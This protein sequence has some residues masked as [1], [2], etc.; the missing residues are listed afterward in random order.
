MR[1]CKFNVKNVTIQFQPW[2]DETETDGSRLYTA[3]AKDLQWSLSLSDPT[4]NELHIKYLGRTGKEESSNIG[5]VYSMLMSIREITVQRHEDADEQTFLRIISIGRV[6]VKCLASQWPNPV[7]SLARKTHGDPNDSLLVLLLDISSP[8]FCERLD[9]LASMLKIWSFKSTS[10]TSPPRR[11]LNFVPRLVLGLFVRD[12]AA[13]LIPVDQPS[14]SIIVSSTQATFSFST[15]FKSLPLGRPNFAESCSS[16]YIPIEL[17]GEGHA[18]LGPA[19]MT[20]LSHRLDLDE[21]DRVSKYVESPSTFGDPLVSMGTLDMQITG[22]ILGGVFGELESVSLDLTSA[23]L[24]ASLASDAVSIELWQPT[25]VA[26]SNQ[27]A[28]IPDKPQVLPR[29]HN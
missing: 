28:T 20:Y 27:L 24:D 15:F 14:S 17:E 3:Y 7:I 19:F 2:Y 9:V 10:K 22:G 4:T 1:S 25:A 29:K 11:V 12:I 23:M 6:A 13:C 26:G 8:Q 5:P 21:S 16:G 18:V